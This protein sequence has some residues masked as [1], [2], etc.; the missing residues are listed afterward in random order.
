VPIDP[1][2]A[3]IQ[4]LIALALSNPSAEEARSAALKAVQM[5][6]DLECKISLPGAP[7]QAPPQTF[8]PFYEEQARA[9]ARYQQ[10]HQQNMQ[11][12]WFWNHFTK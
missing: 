8:P 3:K 6:T 2:L 11:S 10:Q 4:K 9:Y 7:A 5:M 1:R 12:Q